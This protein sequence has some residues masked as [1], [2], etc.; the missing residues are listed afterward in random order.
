M[1]QV[2]AIAHYD[3]VHVIGCDIK[4]GSVERSRDLEMT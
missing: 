1:V 2:D 3:H 4:L